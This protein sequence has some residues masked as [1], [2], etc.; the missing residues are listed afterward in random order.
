MCCFVL[1]VNEK[2][3]KKK[4]HAVWKSSLAQILAEFPE[5][6][7]YVFQFTTVMQ[8]VGVVGIETDS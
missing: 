1:L 6:N 4:F 7:Y 2:Q 3:N 8:I 5:T